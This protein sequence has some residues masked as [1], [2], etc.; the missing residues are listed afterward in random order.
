MRD[1]VSPEQPKVSVIMP[2]RDGERW[3]AEAIRSVQNQTFSD[4]ELLVIDDGSADA[5]PAI[6]A[7][8]AAADPRIAV[9]TQHRDGLVAGLNRGL[10]AARA[11]L[12]ARLDAD[13]IALP[14]RLARQVDYMTTHP[15]V[16]LLGGWATIIDENGQLKGRDMRP[17]PNDLRATLM[18]KSPFIHPTVMFRAEAA[19]RVGGYHAAFE[20]GEDYDFWL[21]LADIG[22]VAILPEL[23]IR[24]REHGASVTR[25]R[26]LRQIY[27]ARLAKLAAAA[28]QAGQPDPSAALI[29]A[30]DW[31]DPSP[32]PFERDSSRLF[33][34]LELGDPAAA[35]GVPPS[36]ID[37][38]A[39]ASQLGSLTAGERK[40]AQAAVLNLL[41][42]PHEVPGISRLKLY[43]LLL[44]L[45]P[46][47]AAKLLIA[48]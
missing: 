15:A 32:G 27:S 43:W 16:V 6:L 42:L 17:S 23:L 36:A 29:T 47:K 2:V 45:G 19:R 8:A 14:D 21:R 26:Q 20:A 44:R 28:R 1:G 48:K 46:L 12:I 33:R 37:L 3:V 18:K 40:F 34:M 13:D 39:I 25:T 4:F 24:Y 35:T 31:H 10:A 22:E 38:N 5:T 41:R 11:P 30:P 9:L 7:D